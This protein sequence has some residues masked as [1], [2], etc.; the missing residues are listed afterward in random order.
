MIQ[1]L[2]ICNSNRT[3]K[4]VPHI[5]PSLGVFDIQYFQKVPTCFC[6]LKYHGEK[7]GYGKC[8]LKDVGD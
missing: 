5:L 4:Q 2:Q 1:P 8:K 3:R 7:P 6:L